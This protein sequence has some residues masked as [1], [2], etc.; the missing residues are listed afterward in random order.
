M[1]QLAALAL[2]AAVSSPPP[3]T[4]PGPEFFAAHRQRVI[5]K[6]PAGAIAV[7]RSAPETSVETSPD[8]YRQESSFWWLTGFGEPNSVAVLRK[9]AAGPR[10]VLFVPPRD[11]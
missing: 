8:P 6:L 9:D 10:Y 3:P 11:P 5:D 7:F 4:R 2:A 1:L